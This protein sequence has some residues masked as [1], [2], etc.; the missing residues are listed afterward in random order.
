[1]EGEVYRDVLTL[2]FQKGFFSLPTLGMSP[3]IMYRKAEMKK[4]IS[5]IILF[6]VFNSLF[7]P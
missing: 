6:F 3:H 7:D 1:M 2:M 5:C 4:K